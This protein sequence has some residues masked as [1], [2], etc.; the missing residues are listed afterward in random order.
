VAFHLIAGGAKA[1]SRGGSSDVQLHNLNAA[2]AGTPFSF[3]LV[4]LNTTKNVDWY[5]DCFDAVYED[6]MKRRLA[7]KP[8]QV[9]NVY[10]CKTDGP[11]HVGVI[12]YAYFSLGA[13]GAVRT[14]R[15]S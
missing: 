14:S 5:S 13:A 7:Y 9:L 1:R 15:G 12:G 3:Y 10:S 6:A 4:R 8:T 11:G 2:F